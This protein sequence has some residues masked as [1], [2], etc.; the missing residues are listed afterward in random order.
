M[1]KTLRDPPLPEQP[2]GHL[3][4]FA[5]GVLHFAPRFTSTRTLFF[6]CYGSDLAMAHRVALL[7]NNDNREIRCRGKKKIRNCGNA[8]IMRGQRS[9]A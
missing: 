8:E 3:G 1:Q 2:T 7:L 6:V 4:S 9:I 5:I